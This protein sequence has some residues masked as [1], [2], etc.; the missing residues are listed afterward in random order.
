VSWWRRLFKKDEATQAAARPLSLKEQYQRKVQ[1]YAEILS[2]SNAALEIMAQMQACLHEK[3]Y[4]SPAYVKLNCAIVLDQ[5]RRVLE[6]LKGFTRGQ[7]LEVA[8]VFARIAAQITDE[9]TLFLENQ[10]GDGV[11]PFEKQTLTSPE[12]LGT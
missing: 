7:N 4:F 11:L 6:S 3:D 10:A 5:A 9:S 2:A 8:G 12:L 1:L